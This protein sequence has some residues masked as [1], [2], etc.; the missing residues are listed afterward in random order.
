[1][2]E[3]NSEEKVLLEKEREERE[4][5]EEEERLYIIATD[6]R[7]KNRDNCEGRLLGQVK[8]WRGK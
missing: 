8:D 7:K 4:E 1:M 6:G 3:F 5:R 2:K